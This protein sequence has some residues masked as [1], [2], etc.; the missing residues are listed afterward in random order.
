M[1]R[2]LALVIA[3]LLSSALLVAPAT[4]DSRRLAVQVGTYDYLLSPDFDGLV[5]A[6]AASAGLT[7]GLGTFDRLDGELVLVGGVLYRVGTDGTPTEVTD[8]R[9]TPFFEGVRFRARASVPV[10]PGTTC[11]AMGPLVT[12]AAGTSAGMVAVRVRGTFS[13]LVTRSVEAGADHGPLQVGP[14]ER[15]REI[16]LVGEEALD[17]GERRVAQLDHELFAVVGRDEV[18]AEL[19]ALGLRRCPGGCR[20][21]RA[22]GSVRHR[23]DDVRAGALRRRAA[24]ECR[25]AAR[26][27]REEAVAHA[28]ALLLVADLLEGIRQQ[29]LGCLRCRARRRRA[30]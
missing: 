22:T 26:G 3:V 29:I 8:D 16:G 19:H 27:R 13:D 28:R 21:S 24:R 18:D 23:A 9:T 12:A 2:R 25:S 30:C 20:G 10:P 4:A 15:D 6:R 7:L 14:V 5:S 1:R 17:V 11:A